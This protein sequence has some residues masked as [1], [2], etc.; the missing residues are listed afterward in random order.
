MNPPVLVVRSPLEALDPGLPGLVDVLEPGAATGLLA[1]LLVRRSFETTRRD[2]PSQLRRAGVQYSPGESCVVTWEQVAVVPSEDGPDARESV[3]DILVLEARPDG[4]HARGFTADSALPGLHDA[5]HA[6]GMRLRL[7]ALVGRE[8]LTVRVTP[9]RYRPGG[10]CVLR[11]DVVTAEGPRVVY[12][13]VLRGEVA[14]FARSL[15]ALAAHLAEDPSGPGVA[16]V[17]GSV[18]GLGLLVQT[19]VTGR[20][21]GRATD[22]L[23][24]LRTVGRQLAALH[25]AASAGLP[26]RRPVADL[27]ETRACLA[28]VL[29]A[30]PALGVRLV[31]LLDRLAADAPDPGACTTHGA[32]RTDQV[33]L[34]GGRLLLLD[35]DELCSA[36]ADRDLA[37]LL[38]YFRWRAVR[39][40]MLEPMLARARDA[41]LGGYRDGGGTSDDRVRDWY[42]RLSL[43]KIAARRYRRLDVDEWD[44]VPVLVDQADRLVSRRAGARLGSRSR[45]ASGLPVASA[46]EPARMTGLLAPVLIPCASSTKGFEV[47]SARLLAAK[48]GVRAVLRY[49]VA[50]LALD[51]AAAGDALPGCV[52]VLG[53]LYREPERAARLDRTL[54]RLGGLVA[55]DGGATQPASPS[56]R[57]VHGMPSQPFPLGWLADP[58][59]ALYLPAVGKPLDELPSSLAADA[60]A[61]VGRW[62]ARLHGADVRFEREVDP[63]A[64]VRDAATWAAVVAAADPDLGPVALDLA[65]RLGSMPIEHADRIVPL[66]KDLHQR[67]LLV[68]RRAAGW[69]LSV[70]DFD[71]ARMGDPSLDVAHLCANLDLL[72]QRGQDRAADWRAVFLDEYARRAGWREG[73][74]WPFW[75]AHACLKMAKQ[76]STGRGPWPVPPDAERRRLTSSVL[77][78]GRDQ[79]R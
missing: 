26:V 65:T 8:A 79:L 12:G 64:E 45:R 40:P 15:S 55:A 58:A 33:R 78:A 18:P 7:S 57:G 3:V 50:G 13:K 76:L 21:L 27:I 63:K 69:R 77:A 74:T 61:G 17:L 4:V 19:E 1:D 68:Q 22:E 32:L 49:D 73:P 46:L 37:N 6:E 44:L 23:R 52:A 48:P 29:H 75:Y 51:E 25:R 35:L 47:R 54:R 53:K 39:Q 24:D 59:L 71:E 62:L 67:H 56:P 5:T 70:I 20:P 34:D 72:Q 60:A 16:S 41:V 2:Q 66:H 10:R 38:A 11:Y 36:P 30:A 43:L 42:E 9:V 31:G 28:A 14:A